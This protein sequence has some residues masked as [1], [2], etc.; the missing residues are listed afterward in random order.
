MTPEEHA[1]VILGDSHSTSLE[2]K[3]ALF[4]LADAI[5]QK[6]HIISNDKGDVF[7]YKDGIYEQD[8]D[9]KIKDY[10][11]VQL[12]FKGELLERDLTEIVFY[13]RRHTKKEINEPIDKICVEN[14]ILDI[15]TMKVIPHT[16]DI[17]FLNKIHAKYDPNAKCPMIMKFLSEIMRGRDLWTLQEFVGWMLLKN[18]KFQKA[19]MLLGG[20]DNGKS[21]FIKLIEAFLGSENIEN[22][23]LQQLVHDKFETASLYGKLANLYSDLEADALKKT[24]TFKVLTS[25][26][27]LTASRK[28]KEGLKFRNYAKLLFSANRLPMTPDDTDAFYRRW[29]IINF[30]FKFE[31][32]LKDPNIIEKI[33]T[34]EEL[35]GFLNFAIDGLKRLLKKKEFSFEKNTKEIRDMYLRLSDSVSAFVMDMI[36]ISPDSYEEKQK[37]FVE[38]TEYCR[39]KGY[40]AVSENSFYK[41]IQQLVR[42]EDYRPKVGNKRIRCF[43]GI[44][45]R[46]TSENE[47]IDRDKASNEEIRVKPFKFGR[48]I[49][50][51]YIKSPCPGCPPKKLVQFECFDK[52][53]NNRKKSGHVGHK[54]SSFVK[55][56]KYEGGVKP[57]IEKKADTLDTKNF[58]SL[59]LKTNFY[60]DF[61]H[62]ILSDL[63]AWEIPSEPGVVSAQIIFSN[64][65]LLGWAKDK[66]NH[67]NEMVKRG[68]FR[69]VRS[70][71]YFSEQ[72]RDFAPDSEAPSKEIKGKKEV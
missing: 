72:L 14:G 23:P 46:D 44:K 28:F 30:P 56:Q 65:N 38:Y 27:S 20:G 55:K 16:P 39:Q 37:F 63:K 57:I 42:V 49:G 3:N 35:S 61:D 32:K 15:N 10:I 51:N 5:M 7:V 26:D 52:L 2:R 1:K 40:L 29:I 58:T 21:T 48:Y 67:F 45:L 24:G 66:V 71:F 19:V 22:K 43:K 47:D 70:G 41:R 6:L 9:E 25:G 34:P 8:G 59:P 4:L 54:K 17:I 18:Y 13:I 64:P 50:Y 60:R 11:R 31:G 68:I 36:D 12:G 62:E 69:E 33:T 53:L